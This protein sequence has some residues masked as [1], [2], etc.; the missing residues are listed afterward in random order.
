MGSTSVLLPGVELHHLLPG[1]GHLVQAVVAA[2]DHEVED[3][4]LE[5][6]AA[7]AGAGLE[8]SGNELP[9]SGF[10]EGDAVPQRRYSRLIVGPRILTIDGPAS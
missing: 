1:G 7:E 5:A 9:P 3:V 6:A 8:R 4:L 2:E 10:R